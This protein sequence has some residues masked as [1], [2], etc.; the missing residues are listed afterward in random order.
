MASNGSAITWRPAIAELVAT[1]LFV[2]VGAGTVKVGS[3]HRSAGLD[4]V[5]CAPYPT[6]RWLWTA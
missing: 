1:F 3:C 2:F 4:T 6:V 5:V